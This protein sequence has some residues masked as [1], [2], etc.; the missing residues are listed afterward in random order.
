MS[1]EQTASKVNIPNPFVSNDGFASLR[2][3][4][5]V[6][7]WLICF[8]LS[9]SGS[10]SRALSMMRLVVTSLQPF[11][12]VDVRDIEEGSSEEVESGIN[13]GATQEIKS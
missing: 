4:Y 13:S 1:N 9:S 11:S 3:S 5:S 10:F 7:I 6:L 8:T 12:S 2:Y